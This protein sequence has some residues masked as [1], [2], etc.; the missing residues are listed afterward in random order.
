MKNKLQEKKGNSSYS[1]MEAQTDSYWTK[2]SLKDTERDWSYG[3]DTWVEDYL[4]SVD[5]PHRVKIV[6][7]LIKKFPGMR[8]LGEIG[9]NCGP[10]LKVIH[11]AFPNV[12][13]FGIDA[14][15]EAVKLATKKVTGKHIEI[16]LG[17]AR[18]L[19]WKDKSI[20]VLL[21]D[22]VLMYV[23]PEE[24]PLVFDEIVRVTKR[25]G[26]L[27][28]RHSES[29]GGEIAGHVRAYNYTKLLK[30]RGFVVEEIKIT[31]ELWPTSKN[32]QKYGRIY[33]FQVPSKT[34]KKS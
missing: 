27:V 28:E 12:D 7:I 32:W 23:P 22:A 29:V 15:P 5:H 20:D 34:G 33:I 14:S 31:K 25:G 19:P 10:N 1:N 8:S 2:R 16:K 17:K 9:C 26:I 11:R 24:I 21:A 13:L 4:K 6:D 3:G 18:K 30:D